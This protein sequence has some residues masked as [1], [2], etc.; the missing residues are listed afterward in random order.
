MSLNDRR[1]IWTRRMFLD[2]L[3]VA[4]TASLLGARSEYAAA[5]DAPPETK[6]LRI[7]QS[8]TGTCWAP[9]YLAAEM[10][11]AEG[12]S[13]LR[14]VPADAGQVYKAIA[15]GEIDLSMAFI[16]PFVVQADSG[17][18][19]VM[20]AGIHP[21]CIELFCSERIRAIRDLKGR[22]VSTNGLGSPNHAFLSSMLTYVGLDPRRDVNW[23]VQKEDEAMRHLAEGKVDARLAA[24]PSSYVLRAKKIGHVV[25]NMTTDR[26][27]SQYFCCVLTGNREFVRKNPVA[28][29]RAVRAILKSADF[30]ATNPEPSA[31]ALAGFLAGNASP[32][33]YELAMQTMREVPY[34]RWRD[35]DTEDTVR[36]Y[37]LRLQEAGLIK[38]TPNKILAQATDFR[39]LNELKK[40][41]KT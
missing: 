31:R 40:E 25:V 11:R 2:R 23:V 6:R 16:A 35:Y 19:V 30:C 37:A 34:A 5:A 12:F 10:L 13:D 41:L 20:L 15:A 26:P 39:F 21:G 27:W 7:G 29:K 38:S 32:P 28:T 4:G 3:A 22:T 24:P 17:Q 36:F 14:Y 33:T 8:P 1:E 9:Q 18:Q